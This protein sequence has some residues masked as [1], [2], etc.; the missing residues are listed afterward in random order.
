[1]LAHRIGLML[2]HQGGWDEIL[3]AAIPVAV[4]A[5]LLRVANSRAKKLSQPTS[6]S[7]QETP[8]PTPPGPTHPSDRRSD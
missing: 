5:V 3:F 6:A 7:S 8:V 1:M 2:A 4:I